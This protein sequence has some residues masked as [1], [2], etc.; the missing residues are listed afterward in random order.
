MRDEIR[1]TDLSLRTPSLAPDHWQRPQKPQPL[2][3]T[4]SISTDVSGEASADDL[5]AESL[6]YGTVTKVVEAHVAGLAG[7]EDYGD[8]GIPLEELA[9]Q[10]AGLI[11]WK[12]SAPNVLLELRRPRAHL[13]AESVGVRIFRSRT[14][15]TLSPSAS[16]LSSSAKPSPSD[17]TLR[18][19]SPSLAKDTLFVRQLSRQIIIGLNPCERED[20]QEVLVDLEFAADEMNV[21]LSNGARAGW[22]GWRGMVKKVE[23]VRCFSPSSRRL[24]SPCFFAQHLSTS[25]PLTIEHICTSVAELIVAPPPASPSPPQWNVPRTIVRISKPAALMFA[26][27]P[28][29]SVTRTRAD[30]FPSTLPAFRSFSSS[31]AGAQHTAYLGI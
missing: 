1:V 6:N 4:L 24:R 21:R 26:R 9:E 18:T 25:A 8:E 12:A 13:R 16:S 5:L 30:F 27:H 17:Y 3:L 20:E 15:Y 10:L 7:K 14:D 28:G 22:V 29:V 19:D 11:L 23:E 31:S 2:L